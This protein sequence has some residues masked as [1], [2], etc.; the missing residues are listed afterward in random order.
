VN[1]DFNIIKLLEQGN[2]LFFLGTLVLIVALIILVRLILNII[3]YYSRPKQPSVRRSRLAL[4][5]KIFLLLIVLFLLSIA[6]SLLLAGMTI[7]TYVTFTRADQIGIIE[8]LSWNPQEKF[9]VVSFS[10]L[11]QGKPVN[12]QTFS[13]YGDQWE[14]SAHILKW[15]PWVNMFGLHT[16]YRLNLIKGSYLKAEDE[17]KRLHR[18]YALT[19]GE[20]WLWWALSRFGEWL[21]FVEAVYGNAVSR[22][23]RPGDKFDIFVTTS[24]L[25]ARRRTH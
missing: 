9:M 17:S 22:I 8:C 16:G 5:R 1:L 6:T 20:D 2:G 18:A 23:A 4:N 25:S 3:V 24:G 19:P 10:I 15:D 12:V 21:P 11:R 14:V 7:R 13:L